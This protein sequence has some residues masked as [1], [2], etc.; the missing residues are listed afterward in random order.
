MIDLDEGKKVWALYIKKY[1]NQNEDR[2]SLSEEN[3]K[4]IKEHHYDSETNV[5]AL[6]SIYNGV[7]DRAMNED[8]KNDYK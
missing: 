1:V 4:K 3:I 7:N 6:L 5:E 8:C 2:L